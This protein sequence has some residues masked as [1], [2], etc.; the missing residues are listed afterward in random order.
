MLQR[1]VRNEYR[2]ELN[3]LLLRPVH[4]LNRDELD[5]FASILDRF[6]LELDVG[7]TLELD[8]QTWFSAVNG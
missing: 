2:R 3:G 8:I 6:E 7:R 4:V 5:T 1:S